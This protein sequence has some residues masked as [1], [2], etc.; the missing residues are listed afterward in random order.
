MLSNHAIELEREGGRLVVVDIEG[1]PI[2]RPWSILHLRR[3]QLPAAVEQ[4]IQLLRGGQ[5]GATSNRP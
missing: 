3:R 1:F 5:W 2:P 4:F